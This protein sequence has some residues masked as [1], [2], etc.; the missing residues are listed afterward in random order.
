MTISA[1]LR[2]VSQRLKHTVPVNKEAGTRSDN[3][4]REY[5]NAAGGPGDCV[6]AALDTGREPN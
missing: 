5:P 3:D 1:S 2:E 4:W 6:P